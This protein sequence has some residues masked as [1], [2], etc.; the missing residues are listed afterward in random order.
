[1]ISDG[2][3]DDFFVSGSH[4][5]KCNPNIVDKHFWFLESILPGAG[6]IS[7]CYNK[8]PKAWNAQHTS[9]Y[10]EKKFTDGFITFLLV[11]H[12]IQIQIRSY[13]EL[14]FQVHPCA[15][16]IACIKNAC[17]LLCYAFVV[18]ILIKDDH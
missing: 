10:V 5:P 12:G 1:M 18:Q 4:Y 7:W 16:G 13:V 9:Y 14:F 17:F 3:L 15:P 8:C 11:F 2:T 6:F